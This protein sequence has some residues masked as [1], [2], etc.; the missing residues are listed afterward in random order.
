MIG[1]F[2]LKREKI[3]LGFERNIE[4]KIYLYEILFDSF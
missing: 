1:I 3:N 2:A 4:N